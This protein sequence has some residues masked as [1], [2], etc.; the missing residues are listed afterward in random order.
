MTVE[1]VLKIGQALGIL[2]KN[3]YE[4]PRILIAKDTRRSGYLLEQA[5]SA[6]ICSIESILTFCQ[7]Q[8][9]NCL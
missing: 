1:M 4:N 2:F 3:K 7:S 6:G 5:L 9:R 8:H